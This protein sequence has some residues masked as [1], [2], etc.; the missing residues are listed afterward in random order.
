MES[1]KLLINAHNNARKLEKEIK[2]ERCNLIKEYKNKSS[3]DSDWYTTKIRYSAFVAELKKVTDT[4][5][6]LLKELDEAEI[7]ENV[8]DISSDANYEIV[9]NFGSDSDSSTGSDKE[10]DTSH[11]IK[12]SVPMTDALSV[13]ETQVKIENQQKE[14]P[15]Q[16]PEQEEETQNRNAPIAPKEEKKE[17]KEEKEEPKREHITT[18]KFVPITP[19]KQKKVEK[20]LN[21]NKDNK[22]N[23]KGTEF[24]TLSN[25]TPPPVKRNNKKAN[26]K[27]G[28]SIN[29]V[30]AGYKYQ[31]QGFKVFTS[32][33]NRSRPLY[34]STMLFCYE[35]C[36]NNEAELRK[37]LIKFGK[38]NKEMIE[39]VMFK[40]S[41]NFGNYALIKV[42]G[43]MSYIKKKIKTLNKA[44][45]NGMINIFERSTI[46]SANEYNNRTNVLYVNN[47]DIIKASDHKNFTKL[48]LQFGELVKDIKMGV[49]RSRDPYAIVHF[50]EQSDA[51]RAFERRDLMFNGKKLQ[52]KFSKF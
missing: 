17:E 31:G 40:V 37:Y 4:F 35:T 29:T 49:D 18:K 7:K 8:V 15:Q 36:N 1:F 47:F 51:I 27:K 19:E 30:R 10:Y 42:R 48:F 33:M 14:Q 43:K 52:I 3:S 23:N 9:S 28:A 22:Q 46:I 50:R 41:F 44:K 32:A 20:I 26:Y 25:N 24:P 11:L 45:G 34:S 16:E 13:D 6:K 5:D 21:G 39:Q 12:Y 2:K 38:F